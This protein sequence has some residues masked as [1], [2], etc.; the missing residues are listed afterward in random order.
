MVNVPLAT[1]WPKPLEKAQAAF[2]RMMSGDA[3]FR[4]FLE[5]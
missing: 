2:D 4:V 1:T 5:M 3:R